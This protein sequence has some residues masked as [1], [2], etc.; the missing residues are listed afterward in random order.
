[1]PLSRSALYRALSDHVCCRMPHRTEPVPARGGTSFRIRST[2]RVDTNAQD[3]ALSRVNTDVMVEHRVTVVVDLNEDGHAAS[4]FLTRPAGVPRSIGKTVFE[5]TRGHPI[6]R[7]LEA[8]G[9]EW[10]DGAPPRT[11]LTP[12]D[13]SE[14]RPRPARSRTVMCGRTPTSLP[15]G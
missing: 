14:C 4:C 5:R 8:L 10:A 3:V 7:I 9:W 13:V 11:D 6:S 1:M 2:A 12:C 15:P